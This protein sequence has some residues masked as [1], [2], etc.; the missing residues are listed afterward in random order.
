MVPGATENT[1]T[2]DFRLLFENAPGLY[3]ILA[4]DLTII[5][6]NDAYNSATLT[7]REAIVGKKL[8]DVFP[9]NPEDHSADGVSNLRA[10]LNFVLANKKAHTMAVQK[11]DIRRHN[12]TFEER[13]WSPMNKPV[14]NKQGDIMYIIHRVEDVTGFVYLQKEYEANDKIA[15]D[16]RQ[17]AREMETEIYNRSKELQQMNEEL[18]RRVAERTEEV[19][20]NEKRFRNTL[21]KMMEGVQII[22]FDWRYQ[23]VNEAAAKQGQYSIHELL[24][25]TMME[26][27]PGIEQTDMFRTLAQCMAD[28]RARFIESELTNY[29]GNK[30]WFEL[31]IQPVPE[32]IFVLSIDITERKKAQNYVVEMNHD[33]ERKVELR[34]EQLAAINKELE[35]FS[36][37]VSHDLRAPLRSIDGFAYIL[38]EEYGNKLDTEGKRLL[39]VVQQNARKMGMLIDNL[40]SFSRLGKKEVQKSRLDMN[41]L[42]KTALAGA[43]A[44]LR[45]DAKVII[46][47]LEPAFG[48]YGL[49]QQVFVNLISNALKY[50]AKNPEAVVE[51]SSEKQGNNVTYSIRDNGVGFDPQYAHKLFGVFQ[52][53]H[54]MEEFEGTG[55]GLAMVQRIVHK[56][57][58]KVWA[59]AALGKGATFYVLLPL[60]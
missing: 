34:T 22:G 7:Q 24:G 27:Y 20:R 38:E 11:Y 36:Y 23:Y 12:G 3:L 8:F 42:V 28:R 59:D 32:G 55:V 21:D 49:V 60:T 53:L 50:S 40:L 57:G 5:A 41:S 9:D 33:L 31:S 43:E 56:H 17:R 37:S 6:V 29:N 35:A 47:D 16:L 1:L 30:S 14:L 46:H 26:K 44:G 54:G 51:I 2:P 10:S 18:E 58:G 39:S 52:R 15:D 45:H 25:Y 13:Y 48:D 19:I 4:P